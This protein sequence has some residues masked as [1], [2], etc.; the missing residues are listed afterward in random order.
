MS[1]KELE[2][3]VA[4]LERQLKQLKQERAAQQN[5][6]LFD[7]EATVDRFKNN[8]HI[9]AVLAEA[10]KLRDRE[11]RAARKPRPKAHRAKP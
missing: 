3:R 11:R 2:Q 6:P 8:E 9:L 7:W 5:G 10:M 1:V 4:A